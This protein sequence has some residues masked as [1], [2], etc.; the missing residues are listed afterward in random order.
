MQRRIQLLDTMKNRMLGVPEVQE[1]FGSRQP[2][3]DVLALMGDSVDNVPGVDGIGPKT[4]AELMT[5]SARSTTSWPT[6]G[7]SRASAERPWRPRARR[8]KISRKL[9]ALRCDVPLP[10]T[11][12]RSGDVEPEKSALAALFRELEFTRLITQERLEQ[13]PGQAVPAQL[14]LVARPTRGA[15]ARGP[16]ADRGRPRGRAAARGGAATATRGRWSGTVAASGVAAWRSWSRAGRRPRRVRRP[17]RCAARFA[18]L[19][20]ALGHRLLG[21]PPGLRWAQVAAEL[22]PTSPIADAQAPPRRKIL[23]VM[24]AP[25]GLTLAGVVADTLLAG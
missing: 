17:G 25:R 18:T 12:R 4:A 5:S 15:H 21:E 16:P 10:T 3:G 9:V 2:R 19:L 1:K 7:R 23:E 6:W 20:P 8:S 13:A 24:L 11:S 22:G 14:E